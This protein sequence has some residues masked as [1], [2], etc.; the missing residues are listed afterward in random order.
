MQEANSSNG[1]EPRPLSD[2][3]RKLVAKATENARAKN[4]RLRL[5]KERN[6]LYRAARRVE[7]DDEDGLDDE[8]TRE[9]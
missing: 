5:L 1:V 8:V 6:E 4:A 7:L 9:L 3:V 2:D